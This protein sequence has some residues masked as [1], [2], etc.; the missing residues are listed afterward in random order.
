MLHA[1]IRPVV[2]AV[3]I[4]LVIASPAAA[5]DA[6]PA[7]DPKPA[8]IETPYAGTSCTSDEHAR[9]GGPSA[10]SWFAHPSDTGDY[11]GYYIGGGCP[12]KGQPRCSGEGTWGW[13]YSGILFSRHVILA[14]SHCRRYQGGIGYYRTVPKP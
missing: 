8:P 12:W 9:A 14:W 2:P 7:P 1:A 6:L 10:I 5:E 3:L 13:D 4:L 11:V